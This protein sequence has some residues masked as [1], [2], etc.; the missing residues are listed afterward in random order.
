[1]DRGPS[2]S[3]KS[4]IDVVELEPFYNH[5]DERLLTGI[6]V[7]MNSLQKRVERH[8]SDILIA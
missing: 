2:S 3:P 7:C 6:P 8:V 5:F 1:M 4:L